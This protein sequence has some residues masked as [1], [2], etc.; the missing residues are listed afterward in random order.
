MY[1]GHIEQAVGWLLG[2][3][4]YSFIKQ[5]TYTSEIWIELKVIYN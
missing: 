2:W 5:I 1:R 4:T 3:V